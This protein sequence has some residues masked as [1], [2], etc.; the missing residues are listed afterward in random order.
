MNPATHASPITNRQSPITNHV[1]IT[2]GA[3]FIGSHLVERLLA[4]GKSVTVLDDVSTG[5]LDNLQAVR[6]HPK[7]RVIQ[8]KISACSELSQVVAGAE[9]I[10]HLAAAAGVELRGTS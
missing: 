2:G 7:L 9:A 5:N 10:Y 4:D 3:G 1:L 6:S 8:S